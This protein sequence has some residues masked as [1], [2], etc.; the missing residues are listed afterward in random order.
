MN[1]NK[2]ILIAVTLAAVLLGGA[3]YFQRFAFEAGVELFNSTSV[4]ASGDRIRNY[5]LIQAYIESGD[6]DDA[7]Q[8]LELLADQELEGIRT[9]TDPELY[10][11]EIVQIAEAVLYKVE[12]QAWDDSIAPDTGGID[13]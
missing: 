7:V 11:E 10:P 12:N 9:M 3:L 4:V 2:T 1:G 5:Q 13:D 8:R 6:L